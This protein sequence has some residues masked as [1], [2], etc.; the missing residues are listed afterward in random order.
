MMTP[1]L[2]IAA[3]LAAAAPSSIAAMRWE[4]RILIV[5]APGDGDHALGEQRRILQ[6]WRAGAADRDL[7]VVEIVGGSVSGATDGAAALRRRYAIP[8]EGFAVV[9]I[10]KDG[11]A[12][13]RAARPVRSER[14]A[15]TIDAMPMRAAG[16]R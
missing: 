15:A 1:T 12:K 10:G 7:V 14:L 3:A 6:S 9:L 2:A 13:L 11:G 5:S 8:A 16:S 4:K